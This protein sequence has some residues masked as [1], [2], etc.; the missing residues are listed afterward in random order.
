MVWIDFG[1][2][3]VHCREYGGWAHGDMFGEVVKEMR[4][5][6]ALRN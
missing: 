1:R 6:G 2:E 4:Y 3:Q 5:G